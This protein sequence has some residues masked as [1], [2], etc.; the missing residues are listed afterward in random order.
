MKSLLAATVL[1]LGCSFFASADQWQ[2]ND[3]QNNARRIDTDKVKLKVSGRGNG[4][5]KTPIYVVTTM[6][7]KPF[8]EAKYDQVMITI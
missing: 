8:T 5:A 1:I 6:Y 3:W 7:E 2:S 4:K